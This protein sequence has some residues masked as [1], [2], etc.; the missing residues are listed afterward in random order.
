MSIG[1]VLTM[2]T[3]KELS[4]WVA[5]FQVREAE[6]GSAAPAASKVPPTMGAERRQGS[7]EELD[8]LYDR[9]KG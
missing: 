7:L 8:A 2:H 3:S 6:S 5:Y 4:E 1:E 9:A